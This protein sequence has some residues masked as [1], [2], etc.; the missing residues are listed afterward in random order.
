MPCSISRRVWFQRVEI[1][2]QHTRLRDVVAQQRR[3]DRHVVKPAGGI[4]TRAE[5]ETEIVGRQLAGVAVG[6]LKQ[7]AMPGRHLPARMRFN[8]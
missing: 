6:Y 1:V 5:G 8:P 2:G 7:R 4:E 3:A